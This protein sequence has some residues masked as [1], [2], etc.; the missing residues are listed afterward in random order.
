MCTP[1]LQFLSLRLPHRDFNSRRVQTLSW[2]P[3]SPLLFPQDLP[4]PPAAPP[5][6]SSSSPTCPS[7]VPRVPHLFHVH[8]IENPGST[9][10]RLPQAF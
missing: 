5:F 10:Q 4:N 8:F 3:E 7:F 9:A 6:M 2:V 1:L